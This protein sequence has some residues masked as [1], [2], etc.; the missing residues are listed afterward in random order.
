VTQQSISRYWQYDVAGN[1]VKEID[2]RGKATLY[3]F[4]DNYGAPDGDARTNSPPAELVDEG[5]TYYSFAYPTNVTNALGHVSRTQ[6]DFHL[7]K[8]VNGEDPNGV[9]WSASYDDPLERQT[10]LVRAV[11]LNEE[12]ATDI[13]YADEQ[14]I[15]T[16][17][18]DQDKNPLRR[19]KSQLI[20][21]CLGREVQKRSYYDEASFISVDREYD[22]AGRLYK[23]SN[24]YYFGSETAQWTT[25][26]YDA[27][28]R[29]YLQT[30]P[31]GSQIQTVYHGN[32]VFLV[33]EAGKERLS[34]Y[35]AF[36]RLTSV[37]EDPMGLEFLTGYSY[38]ALDN[39]K[40]VQ[41][42]EQS[43]VFNYDSLS[44]LTSATYPEAEVGR[45]VTYQYDGNGN[46]TY[47]SD[48]R[49]VSTT[50]EYDDINRI[51]R[52]TYTGGTTVTPRVTYDYD[53]PAV[54]YSI[55]RL[56][57]VISE[58]VNLRISAIRRPGTRFEKQP[59]D[60][61][62]WTVYDFLCVRSGGQSDSGDLPVGTHRHDR[63]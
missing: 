41:Q 50:Y 20:Y 39:L 45:Q 29:V 16:S 27:L 31:G 21:D 10:R 48:Q 46:V 37:I 23:L 4:S 15:V 30:M 62:G 3:G 34:T 61:R 49:P 12:S 40:L 47:R 43:R 9:V 14:R 38:D 33:D 26:E 19:L 63:V 60:R 18:S 51:H 7:G 5:V 28:D 58:G 13:A 35:D 32:Q 59:N 54:Q 44:R 2:G 25:Y 1:V 36:G 24:P 6:Y 8:A 53:A 11:G 42:S 55:G 52:K 17:E 56:T 22:D 57:A